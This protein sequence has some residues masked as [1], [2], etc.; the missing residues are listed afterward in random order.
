MK[1]IDFF[2]GIGG[3][4]LGL[5]MAGHNAVGWCEFD[6]HAQKSYRAMYK[7]DEKGEWFQDDIRTVRADELP[8]A[9]MWTF[10][11]PCQDISVAGNMRGF[12]GE[13]SGL[14]FQIIRLLAET[15]QE[16]KPKW[17]L[18][19]N[20]KNLL[21]IADGSG[22]KGSG[23]LRLLIEL[24]GV[25]YDVE[26]QLLNSKDWGVPQNR[27]RVFIIGHLRG[28]SG[29]KIFPIERTDGTNSAKLQE[30]TQNVGQ[31]HRVYKAKGGLL[32]VWKR[33]FSKQHE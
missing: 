7:P 11:F 19:E 27:E 1:F 33:L 32:R 15:R 30:M 14:F 18:C 9:D 21:S 12:E 4:R 23:F 5:E 24:D 2:A 13:R 22:I 17:L 8:K 3:V 25:G 26:W 29:R 28:S 31:Y 20:V 16:D 6:K 10:G